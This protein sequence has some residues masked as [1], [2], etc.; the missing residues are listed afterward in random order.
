MAQTDNSSVALP[1]AFSGL[2]VVGILASA[3]VPAVSIVIG[4]VALVLQVLTWRRQSRLWRTVAV[5][6]AALSL[7]LGVIVWVVFLPATYGP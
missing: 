4:V 2:S 1:A 7:L 6:T 3:T 5:I